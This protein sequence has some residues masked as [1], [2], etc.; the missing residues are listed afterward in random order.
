MSYFPQA[1]PSRPCYVLLDP[2][3]RPSTVIGGVTLTDTG[4]RENPPPP[5]CGMNID[6]TPLGRG[7][8]MALQLGGP[9]VAE[10]IVPQYQQWQQIGAW[11]QMEV[12]AV[13]HASQN[14]IFVTIVEYGNTGD[15]TANSLYDT[16]RNDDP[17]VY[18]ND[19]RIPT[20]FRIWLLPGGANPGAQIAADILAAGLQDTARAAAARN[21]A[22]TLGTTAT[23]ANF[24]VTAMPAEDRQFWMRNQMAVAVEQ[25]FE[26]YRVH[27]DTLSAPPSPLRETEVEYIMD[28]GDEVRTRLHDEYGWL[29]HEVN[30]YASNGQLLQASFHESSLRSRTLKNIQRREDAYR[31]KQKSWGGGKAPTKGE[32]K[33]MQRLARGGNY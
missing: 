32:V 12:A 22:I 20:Q 9:D 10:N 31:T 7:H 26:A 6:G 4:D 27:F 14:A 5:V 15:A 2:Q 30:M 11:R 33:R 18:W 29:D 13:Q 16:F 23:F 25:S 3:N 21:L 1:F 19:R 24:T 8:V 17:L 28:R